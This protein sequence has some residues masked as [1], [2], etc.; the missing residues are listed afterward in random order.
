MAR[1]IFPGDMLTTL[2]TH[3]V[4]YEMLGISSTDRQRIVDESKAIGTQAGQIAKDTITAV[5]RMIWAYLSKYDLD[6]VTGKPRWIPEHARTYQPDAHKAGARDG[7][8]DDFYNIFNL[9]FEEFFL[10]FEALDI[11]TVGA[12]STIMLEKQGRTLEQ[13]RR[14]IMES[15]RYRDNIA[16]FAT[17]RRE[18][19]HGTSVNGASH[20]GPNEVGVVEV[21]RHK[22][23]LSPEHIAKMKAG[24]FERLKRDREEKAAGKPPRNRPPKNVRATVAITATPNGII[25]TPLNNQDSVAVAAQEPITQE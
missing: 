11:S 17:L 8:P 18:M 5:R 1:S 4:T 12:E 10:N 24:R 7:G 23:Q 2:R 25:S 3:Y 21:G 13:W 6:P 15:K 19:P 20:G 9:H 14:T 22:K 16:I